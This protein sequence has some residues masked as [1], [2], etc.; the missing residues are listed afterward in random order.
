MNPI[1]SMIG[2]E[3]FG[4]YEVD[5]STSHPSFTRISKP[6]DVLLVPGFVDI[7]IHG[8]FGIDFMSASASDLILL[9]TK[10][11][12]E[13]YEAF[14]PTTVTAAPSEI[15]K[16]IGEI[17]ES[18]MIPGFH[19]EGPFISPEF[20]GAQ[21]PESIASVPLIDSDWDPILEH[22]LLKVATVAP[23]IPNALELIL[24]LRRRG[25]LVGMG[26]TNATFGEAR[27][28]YEHGATHTTHTYNAMRGLHHREAGTVGYALSNSEMPAELIYDRHHVCKEAAALLFKNKSDHAVVAVSDGTQ[29]TGV[30]PGQIIEM[31]GH[32]CETGRGTVR[33]VESGALAG[34][35]ITL[36]DAFRNLTEDFGE[37]TA[38]RSCS[39]N[40]RR[41]LGWKSPPKV[42]VEFDRRLQIIGRRVQGA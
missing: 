26:H 20:P 33:L 11:G 34:S 28:G 19:L 21:P 40:P 24:R 8:G 32:K 16:A 13:G 5:W 37:E 41:L 2:P 17:P 1:A 23:E 36:L 18:P 27:N 42:Y 30:P 7:H 3:G 39:L 10:L 31:W 29:A 38:I 4:T 15:L 22:K 12:A 6:P 9:A 35:A 25:V 14:F